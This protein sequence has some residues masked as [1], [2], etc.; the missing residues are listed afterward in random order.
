MPGFSFFDNS[1]VIRVANHKIAK[2]AFVSPTRKL[3]LVALALQFQSDS[4][5]EPLERVRI[6]TFFVS[7]AG[8]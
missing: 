5:Q 4:L 3:G 8:Q 6:V 2:S 1:V 7:L